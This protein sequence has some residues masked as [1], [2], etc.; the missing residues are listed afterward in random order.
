MILRGARLCPEEY[1]PLEPKA[2]REGNFPG[3]VFPFW[4]TKVESGSLIGTASGPDPSAVTVDDALHNGQS[5]AGTREFT[6][7]VEPLEDREKAVRV[8]HIESSAIIA[9]EKC[10]I[11][12]VQA[13]FDFWVGQFTREFPG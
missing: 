11:R 4:Q 8:S 10:A 5:D 12:L 2:A 6:G 13:E 3:R 1:I 7:R 9:H